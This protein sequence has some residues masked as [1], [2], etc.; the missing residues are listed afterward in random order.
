V[1]ANRLEKGPH[2]GNAANAIMIGA[3]GVKRPAGTVLVRGNRFVNDEGRPT[4]FV[5][6]LSETPA[7]LEGNVLVGPVQ[8]LVGPGTVR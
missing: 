6:N 4:V 3:E 5:H 7:V 8:A 2:S 1:D